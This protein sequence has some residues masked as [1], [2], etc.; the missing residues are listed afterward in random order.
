MADPVP[1]SHSAPSRLGIAFNV[2][3]Q[4]LLGAAI[5]VGVNYL[6]YRYYARRDLS[7]SGSFSLSSSTENFL[8]KLAKAEADSL[9]A[10]ISGSSSSIGPLQSQVA[11][12]E[13]QAE[14]V[15][16]RRAAYEML[17]DAQDIEVPDTADE[18]WNLREELTTQ[19]TE[20]LARL[21]RG[22][23]TSTDAE[24]T[25]KVARMARD[26][27]AKELDRVEKVG[28][29][30]PESA[31]TMREFICNAVGLDAAELP[32]VA[33]LLDLRPEHNRWR[34]AVEKVLRG[35]GLRLLVPDRHYAAVLRFVNETDMRGRLQLHH[36]RAS[37]VGAV[38]AG[39]LQ[40]SQ[41]RWLAYR[42]SEQRFIEQ[43]WTQDRFG[44]S[45]SLSASGHR[46][47]LTKARVIALWRYAADAS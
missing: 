41:Q 10:Q 23:E 43:R 35:V 39:G 44:T 7:P 45:A 21:D 13:A 26:A 38:P 3:L 32:Y 28:S 12:A 40:R 1:A 16:R 11:A 22:R 5:C 15:S 2:L 36:V 8:R 17:L 37:L 33:E 19:T 47:A 4:V 9:N 30:L 46:T 14:E 20:L 6:S 42:E 29:A 25:Q 18:F 24:Y 31:I 27:A 34:V